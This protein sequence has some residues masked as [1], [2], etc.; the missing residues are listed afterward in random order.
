MRK[1]I[2]KDLPILNL[3]NGTVENLFIPGTQVKGPKS[4][5]WIIN[6]RDIIQHSSWTGIYWE[7][8]YPRNECTD[9]PGESS[10]V[11]LKK[12]SSRATRKTFIIILLVQAS[13][14]ISLVKFGLVPFA[15]S[16][17]DL[18]Y[19]SHTISSFLQ[20]SSKNARTGW[21]LRRNRRVAI[22]KRLSIN[23]PCSSAR[24]RKHS[25]RQQRA[26][27]RATARSSTRKLAMSANVRFM[28]FAFLR[29]INS[30]MF[31]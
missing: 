8:G 20:F 26:S 11:G 14:S 9:F 2:C 17:S 16:V 19:F 1:N 13:L 24:A 15:L 12:G 10:T 29:A 3:W 28:Q 6:Q 23:C 21:L 4:S 30:N 7:T 25:N 5:S 22:R 31:Y 18:F 27:L